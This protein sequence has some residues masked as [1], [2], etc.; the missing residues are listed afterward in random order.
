MDLPGCFELPIIRTTLLYWEVSS[1]AELRPNR[2]KNKIDSGSTATVV[3]GPHNAEMI[4]HLGAMGVDGIW[5]EGEHGPVDFADMQDLTRACDLWG[6][7]SIARVNV[8]LPGVIYRALD[9]GAQAVCVP[10]INTAEEARE[11]ADA[12]KFYPLGHR[13][14]YTSRQGIGVDNYHNKANAETL[15]IILIEDIVAV[16][17]LSEILEVDGIDIFFVAPGDLAQSMGRLGGADHPEVQEVVAS[18]IKQIVSSGRVAGALVSDSTLD[19]FLDLGAQLVLTQW[20]GWTQKGCKTFLD[21]L[22]N[23]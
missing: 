17:N 10:H 2:V 6:M 8:N 12:S 16:N 9:V 1:L 3:T 21:K 7:T 15:S 20:I 5:M 11:V 18:S 22:E 19:H 13:G 23:R 4:E 14:N